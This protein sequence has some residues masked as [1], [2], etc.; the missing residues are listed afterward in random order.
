MS[1]YGEHTHAPEVGVVHH[2][3]PHGHHRASQGSCICVCVCVFRKFAGPCQCPGSPVRVCLSRFT[4]V[5]RVEMDTCEAPRIRPALHSPPT[6]GGSNQGCR[7]LVPQT[8]ALGYVYRWNF[9][10]CIPQ[11]FGNRGCDLTQHE[12]HKK[13][14]CPLSF[15]FCGADDLFLFF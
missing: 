6:G 4:H 2:A 5:T 10:C 14:F 11:V 13:T 9:N 3:L 7:V 15:R 12:M 1:G 8:E